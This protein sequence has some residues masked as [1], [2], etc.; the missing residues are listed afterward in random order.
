M[1]ELAEAV[2]AL[3]GGR[4]AEALTIVTAAVEGATDSREEETLLALRN[5]CAWLVGDWTDMATMIKNFR[6]VRQ[7][8]DPV[9]GPRL[10]IA[11]C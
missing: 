7:L 11:S 6:R 8:A 4:P 2:A 3:D 1:N 10:A 5:Y 9:G